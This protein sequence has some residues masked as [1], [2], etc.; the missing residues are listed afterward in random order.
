VARVLPAS[1]SATTLAPAGL[2]RPGGCPRSGRGPERVP[3]L[4]SG[5]DPAKEITG[6]RSFTYRGEFDEAIPLLRR[7]D[8]GRGPHTD[9]SL[10]RAPRHC[11][12]SILYAGRTRLKGPRRSRNC[13]TV[14]RRRPAHRDRA[15]IVDSGGTG[16]TPNHGS[17]PAGRQPGTPVAGGIVRPVG[18][19]DRPCVRNGFFPAECASPWRAGGVC[20]DTDH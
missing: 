18:R 19:R 5:D 1:A 20:R 6:E 15:K 10:F 12:A 3:G 16:T 2:L 9:S 8:R 17:G 7:R 13:L 4:A 11:P 14:R